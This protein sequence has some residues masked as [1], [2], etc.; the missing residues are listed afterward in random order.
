MFSIDPLIYIRSADCS[1]VGLPRVRESVESHLEEAPATLLFALILV[2]T[3][4]TQKAVE[5]VAGQGAMVD[6]FRIEPENPLA[7]VPLVLSPWAAESP[8]HFAMNLV[9]IVAFG[10]SVER[11]MESVPYALFVVVLGMVAG[12][13]K[14]GVQGVS[15]WGASRFTVAIA[16][17]WFT[18][19]PGAQEI[20][21]FLFSPY[22]NQV[23][24]I[25]PWFIFPLGGV[26]EYSLAVMGIAVLGHSPNLSHGLAFLLAAPLAAA[27]YGSF[28]EAH[29]P[30]G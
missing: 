14:A 17:A 20:R 18:A 30:C 10:P 22:P 5:L 1:M 4:L 13:F 16:G 8:R 26:I 23:G 3:Y 11:N 27:A 24:R 6:I 28:T 9:G 15:S 21:E 2:A 25:V 7:L 19:S 29:G 12:P